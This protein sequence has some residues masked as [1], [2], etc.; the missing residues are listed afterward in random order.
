M[1][2][3]SLKRGPKHKSNH[4]R[5][6]PESVCNEVPCR[7]GKELI[8]TRTWIWI[9][10]TLN[11]LQHSRTHTHTHIERQHTKEIELNWNSQTMSLHFELS[12][13]CPLLTTT[14]IYMMRNGFELASPTHSHT[15]TQPQAQPAVLVPAFN[16]RPLHCFYVTNNVKLTRNNREYL[17]RKRKLATEL[18]ILFIGTKLMRN[19]YVI[20]SKSS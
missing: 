5:C 16:N 17:Q 1:K 3:S 14:E 8:T 12:G 15:H 6:R 4:T 19:S 10:I 20:R 7:T 2:N 13:V 9:T 11:K 18:R